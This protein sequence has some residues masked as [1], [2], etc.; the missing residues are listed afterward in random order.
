MQSIKYIDN[1]VILAT[2]PYSLKLNTLH[3]PTW[4]SKNKMTADLFLSI[5]A[6]IMIINQRWSTKCQVLH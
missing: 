4:N 5:H 2:E 6:V 1:L 3:L